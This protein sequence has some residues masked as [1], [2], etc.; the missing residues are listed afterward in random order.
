MPFEV[1]NKLKD[2]DEFS[3]IPPSSSIDQTDE[4]TSPMNGELIDIVQQLEEQRHE[5]FGSAKQKIQ[6]SQ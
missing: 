1:A 3:S 6:K 5:I 2:C 4:V